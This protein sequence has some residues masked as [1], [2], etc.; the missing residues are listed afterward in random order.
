M[1][2]HD[3]LNKTI[4]HGITGSVF[5]APGIVQKNALGKCAS[6]GERVFKY[7]STAVD[8]EP[9]ELSGHAAPTAKLTD[10]I[11]VSG[12]YAGAIGA[13]QVQVT[14]AGVTKNLYAGGYLFC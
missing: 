3:D 11:V 12:S 4:G 7:V 2:V 1:S 14:A 9:G 13:T 8:I 5:D 6:V 10:K